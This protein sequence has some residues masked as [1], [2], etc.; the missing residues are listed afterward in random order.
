MGVRSHSIRKGLGTAV[1]LAALAALAAPALA[2]AQAE[3]LSRGASASTPGPDDEAAEIVVTGT[4]IRSGFNAPVPVQ[5]IGQDKLDS[6]GATQFSD[7]LKAIPGNSGS[8]AFTEAQPRAGNAQFNLRGLGYTSTLTLVNGRRAGVS[9]LTDETGAE[10]VDINQFPLAMVGRVEVLKDGASAIYGSDA[11]AGVVNIITRKGYEGLELSGGYQDATNRSWN[12]NLATGK[13]FDGGSFN[14]YA[15][16]FHQTGNVRTDFDW[17]VR[18]VG[19]DGVPGRSQLLNGTGAPA[20]YRRAALNAA[21]QPIGAAGGIG[22][23]DPD[24]EAAGGVFRINDNGTVDR[25][26]CL[27]D[28]ADQVGIIPAAQR[29]QVFAEGEYR[30]ADGV[31]F[32]GEAS[33]SRNTLV[34]V[35]GPGSY[36]NGAVVSNSAGNIFIPASHPFNFFKVDPTNANRLIYVGPANWNPAV[37]T[38]VDLVAPSRIFG[39]PYMGKQG[40][41]ERRTVTNYFRAVAG[42]EIDITSDWQAKL[43]YQ[44]GTADSK[45]LQDYRYNADLLNAALLAGTLNPFGTAISNP[46]LISPKNPARRAGNSPDVIDQVTNTSTEIYES[47]QH[48]IDGVITGPLFQLPGGTAGIAVGGQYRRLRLQYTPDAL[49]AA[50]EGDNS[51]LLFPIDGKNSVYAAY[52][53]LALPVT[54]FLDAQLA[55]RYED[56]GGAV[57]SSF[58]PKAAARVKATDWLSLRGSVSTSFQA[59]TITQTTETFSRSFVNDPTSFDNGQLVCRNSNR[60]SNPLVRTSGDDNLKPQKSFN[61]SLGIVATPRPGISFSVDYWRY[62]YK[63]LIAAGQSAQAII[64]RDCAGDGIPN[65]PRILRG[66]SGLI[67]EVQTSYV[68]VGRVVTDGF[69]LAASYQFAPGDLGRFAVNLDATYLRKFDVFGASGPSFDGAGSRNFANNFRTMPKWRGTGQLGWERGPI[70]AS[71]TL[72]YI[73]GYKN[74]QSN[75]API[76]SWTTVDVSLAYGLPVLG[77][78]KP[79]VVTVGADNLFDRDP[80]ALIKY[81]ANGKLITNATINYV[82]RPGYDAYSGADLR[83]RILYLRL[84]QEF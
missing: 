8:E 60:T 43:S 72:R 48:V 66:G 56:Y 18:R 28:F 7:I 57:G 17:L 5:V 67:D 84:K 77:R 62:R 46:N 81:D 3:S 82:D 31:K 39:A 41:G 16:Y 63:D 79:L 19:G 20:T 6:F 51:N 13:R 11:V 71:I 32:F 61:Y 65:D 23:A 2:L 42:L 76:S 4:S 25:T 49:Q 74:D 68:N 29:I 78:D 59:P 37:D 21:G 14:V 80:P 83:G 10:F 30:L 36:G 33:F 75:D 64:D 53:E 44:Y 73:D 12:V 52:A 40:G 70:G 26:Q 58:N 34:S 24:C 38:A 50:G 9:P 47:T 27:V 45:D 1:S 55:A 54:T 22:F 15:T 69:D 35:K